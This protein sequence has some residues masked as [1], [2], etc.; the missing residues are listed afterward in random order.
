MLAKSMAVNAGMM[1][2][3]DHHIGRLIEYLRE[4]GEYD[5]TLFMV[6]SDNGPEPNRPTDHRMF[7]PWMKLTGYHRDYDTLGEKG[8]FVF[9]G[10]EFA[11]AAASPGAF[12]K[13]YAGEG[14][15]RVPLIVAGPGIEQGVTDAF[16]F[17][18]DITPTLLELTGTTPAAEVNGR[19]LQT[20][21]GRPLH[22]VLRGEANAVY[23]PDDVIGMEAMGHAAVFRGDYKLVRNRPPLGDGEWHLYNIASDPG[24]TSNLAQARPELLAELIDE[25]AAYKEYAGVLEVP[26]GYTPVERMA[27]A[28]RMRMLQRAA[29]WLVVGLIVTGGL[30]MLGL[31]MR[32]RKAL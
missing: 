13:F 16:S 9:I 27:H 3:M 10:P 29:P 17:A 7:K 1:E 18:T 5:N 15:M 32:R 28:T 22:R 26:T 30:I 8:S 2:A 6:L 21:D 31:F 20:F 24:E 4:I 14:G 23:G 25:Y 12:F 19:P 11:S